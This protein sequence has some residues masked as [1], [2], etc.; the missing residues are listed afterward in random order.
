MVNDNY[1]HLPKSIGKSDPYLH[2]S[3]PRHSPALLDWATVFSINQA[4]K[5]MQSR[6]VAKKK[7]CWKEALHLKG[8]PDASE[9][10]QARLVL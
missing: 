4:K 7:T 3:L 5:K 2:K 8:L 10:H 6:Y 1:G 9:R